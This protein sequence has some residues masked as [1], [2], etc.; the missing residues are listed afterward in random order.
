V[1]LVLCPAL[2]M[3]F[4][5]TIYYHDCKKREEKVWFYGV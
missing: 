3:I 4:D 5:V 2:V 1:V